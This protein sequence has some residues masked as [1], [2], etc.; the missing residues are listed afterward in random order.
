MV[1]FSVCYGHRKVGREF[2]DFSTILATSSVSLSPV[3][4]FVFRIFIV[5]LGLKHLC[6]ANSTR[7]NCNRKETQFA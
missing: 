5:L 2:G 6:V 3:S 7:V 4:Y 1:D